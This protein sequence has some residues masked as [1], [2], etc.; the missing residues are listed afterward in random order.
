MF[1]GVALKSLHIKFEPRSVLQIKQGGVRLLDKG[2]CLFGAA[3]RRRIDT[4]RSFHVHIL[5]SRNVRA[6][7]TS[8]SW[9]H[10]VWPCQTSRV[11]TLYIPADFTRPTKETI[12]VIIAG[13]MKCVPKYCRV[14]FK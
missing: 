3:R 4:C 14:I 6:R 1:G 12:Q 7:G 9:N 10:L 8:G 13:L 2:L 11:E 5:L